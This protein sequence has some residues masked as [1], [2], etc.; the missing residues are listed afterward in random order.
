MQRRFFPYGYY[1]KMRRHCQIPHTKNT[2]IGYAPKEVFSLHM[3]F[4]AIMIE[5]EVV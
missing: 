1:I 5:K 3:I 4:F 2:A